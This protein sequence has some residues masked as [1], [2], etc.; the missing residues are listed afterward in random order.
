MGVA[1]MTSATP[2]ARLDPSACREGTML[3]TDLE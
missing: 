2:G 3:K 1:N